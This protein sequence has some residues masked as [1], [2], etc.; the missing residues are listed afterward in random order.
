AAYT[1]Q[2]FGLARDEGTAAA[3][4]HVGWPDALASAYYMASLAGGSAPARNAPGVEKSRSDDGAG[5][6]TFVNLPPAACGASGS[7][8]SPYFPLLLTQG[9]SLSPEVDGY[10]KAMY[11]AGTQ[12][13]TGSNPTGANDGGFGFVFG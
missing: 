1:G 3:G 11:P 6:A 12:Y 13:K 2:L 10:L 7:V 9:S 5:T 8:C 4:N